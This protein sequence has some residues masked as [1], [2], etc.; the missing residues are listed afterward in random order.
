MVFKYSSGLIRAVNV[1][2]KFEFSHFKFVIRRE[3]V[4]ALLVSTSLAQRP[5]IGV[6]VSDATEL[7]DFIIDGSMRKS[8][9]YKPNEDSELG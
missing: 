5:S 9:G 2:E 4:M 6:L 1:D 3:V 7:C 8:P